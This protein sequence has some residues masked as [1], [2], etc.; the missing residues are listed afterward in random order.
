MEGAGTDRYNRDCVGVT[1]CV[2][3]EAGT[4]KHSPEQQQQHTNE[5]VPVAPWAAFHWPG[6]QGWP[7][8]KEEHMVTPLDENSL[9]FVK[10]LDL[11]SRIIG[12]NS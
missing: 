2:H 3:A 1:G 7:L 8:Q 12:L 9:S 6:S 11:G 10:C 4:R 5:T